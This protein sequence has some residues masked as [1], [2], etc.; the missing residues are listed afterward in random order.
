MQPAT[1]PMSELS[2][3]AVQSR[4]ELT[5]SAFAPDAHF[6]IFHEPR[7]NDS[8]AIQ[9][10]T[11]IS[12]A[13]NK[14]TRPLNGFNVQMAGVSLT[15]LAISIVGC[16]LTSIQTNVGDRFFRVFLLELAL[17]PIPIYWH[18]KRQSA[19]RDSSLVL[20]WTVAISTLLT[21][22]I[23]TAARLHL[24][25]RDSLLAS[26]D[27]A[28]GVRVPILI[29][30]AQNHHLAATLDAAYNLLKPLLLIAALVPGL[31][32]KRESAREFLMANLVAFAIAI[33]L[34]ALL[35][36]IGPWDY[37]HLVPNSHQVL[38]QSEI[39]NVRLPGI[40]I[41]NWQEAHIVCFPS[42]HVIWALLSVRALWV[43]RTL[44]IPVSVLAALVI[45]STMTTGWHYFSDVL[46]G[47]VIAGIAILTAN[48][49]TA[50]HW[51]ARNPADDDF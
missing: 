23:L 40:Y 18:K 47:I 28:L 29:T 46:G 6:P 50:A 26:V 30:W 20:L 34:F 1:N 9:P 27:T 15:L 38:C 21:F 13:F 33:P 43:F 22:P 17:A 7:L 51:P 32:G 16:K 3:Q 11:I 36:G 45:V 31:G 19:R 39:L 49:L 14:M 41:Y 10:P 4:S 42:F 2:Q 12:A 5:S 24:P 35:P 8:R 25:L 44:R 37:Y 48:R